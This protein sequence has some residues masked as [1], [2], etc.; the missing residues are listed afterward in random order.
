MRPRATA[1]GFLRR[2]RGWPVASATT[3][4]ASWLVSRLLRVLERLGILERYS[5]RQIPATTVMDHRRKLQWARNHL[6]ALEASMTAW[7]D[8][9][10]YVVTTKYDAE[11]LGYI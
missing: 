9:D 4:A 10:P 11:Q 7:M 1:A 2:L 5:S 3:R 6:D 8:S